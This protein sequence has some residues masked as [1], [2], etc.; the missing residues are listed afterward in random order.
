MRFFAL[1]RVIRGLIIAAAAYGVWRF[2]A[3]RGSIEGIFETIDEQG[4]MIVRTASGARV[5]VTAGDVY[6]GTAASAGIA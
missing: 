2:S 5:P 3:H 6:F 1:E 4:C